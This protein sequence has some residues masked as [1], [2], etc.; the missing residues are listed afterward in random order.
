MILKDS[1]K[2]THLTR[3]LEP[4]AG[5]LDPSGLDLLEAA[6]LGQEDGG[7]LLERSLGLVDG[8]GGGGGAH[9]H[10]N[11]S[12][13]VGWLEEEKKRKRNG[14]EPCSIY[15]QRAKIIEKSIITRLVVTSLKDTPR[16]PS[17]GW[18]GE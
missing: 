1:K 3:D 11:A 14:G 7:L 2:G 9:T 16:G 17:R 13:V 8:G 18:V 5:V 12:K 6:L 15:V 4:E 10:R